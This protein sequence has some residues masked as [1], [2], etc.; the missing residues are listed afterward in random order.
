LPS[1][2]ATSMALPS[3]PSPP[4]LPPSRNEQTSFAQDSTRGGAKSERR[5]PRI[6]RAEDWRRLPHSRRS[7]RSPDLSAH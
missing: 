4:P 5:R 3:L 7:S 6:P 1:P 2:R